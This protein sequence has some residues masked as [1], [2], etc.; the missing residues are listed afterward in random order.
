MMMCDSDYREQ[1][2]DVWEREQTQMEQRL[3]EKLKH[4]QFNKANPLVYLFVGFLT[5]ISKS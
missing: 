3:V 1:A 5:W 2:L 4:K